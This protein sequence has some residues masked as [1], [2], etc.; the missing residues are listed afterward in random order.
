MTNVFTEDLEGT[1]GATITTTGTIFTGV[2]GT[3]SPTYSTAQSKHGSSSAHCVT[4]A[5]SMQMELVRANKTTAFWSFYIKPAAAPSVNSVLFYV[6]STL[7]TTGRTFQVT[8]NTNLTV[9]VQQGS[10]ATILGSATVST[11]PLN[12]WSRIDVSLVSG[13]LTFKLYAGNAN[14]DNPINTAAAG[15]TV[16]GTVGTAI[17]ALYF[18]VGNSS[19]ND[20]YFD[21]LREDDTVFPGPVPTSGVVVPV[22]SF[23]M[24]APTP[25]VEARTYITGG[26]PAN[27]T[28]SIPAPVVTALGAG[29]FSEYF[30]GDNLVD[31]D[32]TNSVFTGKVGDPGQI[33]FSTD[34][35][36][37]GKGSGHYVSNGFSIYT[38]LNQTENAAR[39]W[40]IYFKPH[41]AYPNVNTAIFF[42]GHGSATR[43]FQVV[44]NTS[45]TMKLQDNTA[46][47]IGSV[48]TDTAPLEQWS[49]VDISIVSGTATM[50]FYPGTAHCDDPVGTATAGDTKSGSVG[51][52]ISTS[53]TS[54][55]EITPSTAD[56]YFDVYREAL[57]AI[58][59]PVLIATGIASQEAEGI[60]SVTYLLQSMS[61]ASIVSQEVFGVPFANIT[62][63][64]MATSIVSSEAFGASFINMGTNIVIPMNLDLDASRRAYYNTL[65]GANLSLDDIYFKFLQI[66]TGKTNLSMQD[67][68]AIYWG[69]LAGTSGSVQDAK[70]K[71]FNA[72]KSEELY[73]LR[74]QP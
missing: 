40:T 8:L 57:L 17:T 5:Q 4:T 35:Y 64:L 67:M 22:V 74:S 44:L 18:G 36:R 33:V 32:S 66:K 73:Y 28:Y 13:A 16:T 47:I 31:I 34:T 27:A 51:A 71:L 56:I 37:A 60:P 45:G 29:P 68:E 12:E 46:T 65:V 15:D 20:I 58:P 24:A 62:K 61:A 59:G 50:A 49:R 38:E 43:T 26:G 63:T 69:G 21:Y 42:C 48:T 55:G 2:T 23:T 6:G 53:Y 1:N 19:N 70:N 39:Y 41:T 25:I 14:C 7:A 54:I 52:Q 9:K 11:C 10:A 3:A 30:E 72:F